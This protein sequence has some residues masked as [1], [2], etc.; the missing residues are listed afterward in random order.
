MGTAT[1]TR[2]RR[3]TS[4]WT[5]RGRHSGTRTLEDGFATLGHDGTRRR[6]RTCRRQIN[7]TRP[8]LGHNQPTSGCGGLRRTHARLHRRCCRSSGTR[9]TDRPG[10]G[11][12]NLGDDFGGESLGCN[13]SL[14]FVEDCYLI[15]NGGL[16]WLRS[17]GNGGR[18]GRR[19]GWWG[20]R[21]RPHNHCGW[22]TRHRLWC[23]E[24]GCGLRLNR[25]CRLRAGG[26][27]KRRCG[28][29]RNSRRRSYSRPCGDRMTR[30][31]DLTRRC[32][33]LGGPLR[34]GL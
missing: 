5:P 24:T 32:G 11:G 3:R 17:F 33:R 10:V 7:R 1:L 30:R 29:W 8:G 20:W 4:A 31:R 19:R 23:D 26:C 22:W 34:D 16:D 6:C 21:L 25:R 12:F 28:L 14:G 9:L 15:L 27:G 2:P 13:G 18:M